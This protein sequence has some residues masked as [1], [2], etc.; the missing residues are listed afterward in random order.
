MVMILCNIQS[1][2]TDPLIVGSNSSFTCLYLCLP[3]LLLSPVRLTLSQLYHL[4]SVATAHVFCL[5]N[6]F[7][8]FC[9]YV[10]S[11]HGKPM[12]KLYLKYKDGVSISL[13]KSKCYVEIC[14]GECSK[15]K[16]KWVFS[17]QIP[18]TTQNSTSLL[19]LYLGYNVYIS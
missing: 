1:L 13:Y 5:V 19:V 18:L 15:V 14:R 17:S 3:P 8:T 4:C 10:K 2:F 16:A 11:D 9:Q 7:S 6:L 12:N